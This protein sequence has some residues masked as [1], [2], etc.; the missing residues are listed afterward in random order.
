MKKIK[1]CCK[2]YNGM[3]DITN[4]C[5]F[6]KTFIKKQTR[7]SKLLEDFNEYCVEN[8]ELRFW[9]ALVNWA[10]FNI[11]KVEENKGKIN[12][13]DVFYFEEKNK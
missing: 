10:G 5:I 13:T 7:N 9:Q 3:L 12:Y 8:S 1:K 6:C 2:S 4:S 11:S